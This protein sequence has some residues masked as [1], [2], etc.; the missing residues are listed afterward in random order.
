MVMNKRPLLE[1]QRP[2]I[3][4]GADHYVLPSILDEDYS[5][6]PARGLSTELAVQRFVYANSCGIRKAREVLHIPRLAAGQGREPPLG[7]GL[8][9]KSMENPNL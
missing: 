3:R 8:R 4:Q 2:C 5:N 1:L 9:E 7:Q 6:H